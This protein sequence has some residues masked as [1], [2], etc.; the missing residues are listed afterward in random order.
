MFLCDTMLRIALSPVCSQETS[1]PSWTN[2]AGDRTLGLLV[3]TQYYR[4]KSWS[5][6]GRRDAE[7]RKEAESPQDAAGIRTRAMEVNARRRMGTEPNAELH[8]SA[9]AAGD[10]V[11]EWQ[12][13]VSFRILNFCAT[14]GEEARRRFYTALR[15]RDPKTARVR[16]RS[17][18]SWICSI[19]D[20]SCRLSSCLSL[21]VSCSML[22]WPARASRQRRMQGHAR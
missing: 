14:E 15:A 19:I 16:A 1:R 2:A 20:C 4:A 18:V 22:H 3:I 21:H 8:T 10:R 9:A 11:A 5:G 17:Y 12:R 13:R 7:S 6:A